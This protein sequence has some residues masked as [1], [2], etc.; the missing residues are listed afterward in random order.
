VGEEVGVTISQMLHGLIGAPLETVLGMTPFD[1]LAAL[2][3]V[4]IPLGA[5]LSMVRWVFQRF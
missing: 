2:V 4:A 3:L 5:L 1:L